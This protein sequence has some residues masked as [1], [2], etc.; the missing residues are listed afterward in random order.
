MD[1]H[2][3]IRILAGLDDPDVVVGLV[4]REPLENALKAVELRVVLRLDMKGQWD[5]H[6]KRILIERLVVINNIHE[7]RFLVRQM[8]VIFQLIVH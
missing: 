7:K 6:L 1:A 8:K 4:L 5:R 2:A 3:A